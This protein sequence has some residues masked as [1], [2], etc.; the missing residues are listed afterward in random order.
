MSRKR[1]G[2]HERSAGGVVLDSGNVCVI[3]P[4]R[5]TANGKRALALPKGHIDP[6]ESVE[7]T[8]TREVREETG[9]EVELVRELGEVRYWYRRDGK[10]IDKSVTFFEFRAVGGDFADHDDEV[11]EVRWMPVRDALGKLTF[12]GE[13]DMLRKAAGL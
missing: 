13:R 2:P 1:R 3:V 10:S 7:Q 8:A 5:R 9:L 12:D 4:T 11:E 6:G